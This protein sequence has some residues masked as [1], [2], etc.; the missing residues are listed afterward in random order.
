MEDIAKSNSI[1][2]STKKEIKQHSQGFDSNANIINIS[3]TIEN[4]SIIE[5][6]DLK[7]KEKSES[8]LK[9]GHLNEFM[10]K[11][12]KTP[13]FVSKRE[14]NEQAN[15]RLNELKSIGNTNINSNND[16]NINNLNSI[17]EQIKLK[18]NEDS[19]S[20]D[21]YSSSDEISMPRNELKK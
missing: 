17:L 15:T 6:I 7:L 4:S 2:K 9:E 18:E 16:N 5:E 11:K 10:L 1:I 8:Y 3:E 14:L 13:S 19:I 12:S 21:S 20:D